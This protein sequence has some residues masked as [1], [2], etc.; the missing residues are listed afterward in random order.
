MFDD[1]SDTH[2][3]RKNS[4]RIFTISQAQLACKAAVPGAMFFAYSMLR[5][6]LRNDR[7]PSRLTKLFNW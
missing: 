7:P 6:A 4:G 1:L 2:Y 5:L 3:L